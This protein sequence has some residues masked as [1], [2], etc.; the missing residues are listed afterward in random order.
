MSGVK[1]ESIFFELGSGVFS[2]FT[3]THKTIGRMLLTAV[4]CSTDERKSRIPR[5]AKIKLISAKAA[6]I[7]DDK[8]L[9][10]CLN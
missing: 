10:F 5:L 4:A 7:A 9:A 8:S 6:P 1:G 2:A 3:A